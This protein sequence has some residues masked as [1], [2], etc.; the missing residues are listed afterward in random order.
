MSA[1]GNVIGL[2]GSQYQFLIKSGLT[3]L[4]NSYGQIY[5][6]DEKLPSALRIEALWKI[7][8]SEQDLLI[9]LECGIILFLLCLVSSLKMLKTN[10]FF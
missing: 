3:G 8:Q 7:S 4:L 1:F 2:Q 6:A 5:Y 10:F 9:F